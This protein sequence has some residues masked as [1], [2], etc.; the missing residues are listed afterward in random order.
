[1]PYP[2]IL[3]CVDNSVHSRHA[4]SVTAGLARAG[5]ST[6]T[7]AHVYAARLHDRRFA[8]LEPGL[9]AEYQ[10]PRRLERSRGVHDSLIGKGLALISDSYL[11]AARAGLPEIPVEGK[12]L[13][14][15][16][17]VELVRESANG[18]ALA[19]IGARGLGLSALNGQC[20]ADALGSVC[21]RFLRRTRTD[22]LVVK[23]S[24]P[25][26]E[27]A[28]V[29]V[30]GSPESYAALRK[31]L[32]LAKTVEAAACFDPN[33]HPVAFR[34]IAEVLSEKD[35]KVFRFRE[36]EDLHD[37]VIDRG[38]ENL[39]RGHLN[40]A[41]IVAQGRGQ[42]IE[43]R[44][45]KGKPA[46]ELVRRA[47]EID[48]TLVVVA[49]FGL[50][51]TDDLDIGST[52]EAV[53]RLSPANVLV[54][55]EKADDRSPEW[56]AEAEARLGAVPEFMRPMVKK[57]IESYAGARGIGQITPD[58]VDAAKTSHGVPLPGHAR[59]SRT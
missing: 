18:Y 41:R 8:D 4:V 20:P 23:D 27:R 53:V 28:L 12:S 13:E 56:S 15:K 45:L 31:A 30:D 26:A 36:Q 38:L 2:R 42:E 49:R 37:Q 21:E 1:M 3:L 40:N 59:E 16:H 54:V 35:A 58:V 48:A 11:E 14:G 29:G 10:D 33:F 57:A 51:R 24:R 5:R 44:L 50:H 39:Y 47:R 55:N 17:Y 32:G 46:F 7:A 25:L 6:V 19:V 34:S 52:A 22:A 9:P 43:T